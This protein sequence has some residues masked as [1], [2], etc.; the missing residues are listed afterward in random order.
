LCPY[1]A[2]SRIPIAK[3]KSNPE[4]V[5]HRKLR[6]KESASRVWKPK[7]IWIVVR[8]AE[9][10]EIIGRARGGYRVFFAL[11]AGTGMRAGEAL[12]LEVSDIDFDSAL[13]RVHQ[14]LHE[15]RVTSRKTKSGIWEIDLAPELLECLRP[16]AGRTGFL[17]ST[18]R[19]LTYLRTSMVPNDLIQ[20]WI[21]HAPKTVTDVYSKI[22]SDRKFRREV[23]EKVGLGFQ[24]NAE[25]FHSV[26]HFS[27]MNSLQ[28]AE[29]N[30]AP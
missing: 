21:G 30:G 3:A 24:L 19:G 13:I 4:W 17:F 8:K 25:M 11:L 29:I 15:R 12:A 26:P 28:P 5:T 9:I 2:A 16:S 6:S 7:P 18:S 22:K 27:A 23:A 1:L 14:N 10:E 20:Y